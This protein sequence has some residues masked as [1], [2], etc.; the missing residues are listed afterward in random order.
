MPFSK[1]NGNGDN[2]SVSQIG[3]VIE[4]LKESLII[5]FILNTKKQTI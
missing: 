2:W 5:A 4:I 3:S 1:Y